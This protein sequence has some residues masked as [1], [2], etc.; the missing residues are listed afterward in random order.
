[1]LLVCVDCVCWLCVYVFVSVVFVC[2]FVCLFVCALVVCAVCL[3]CVA[4]RVFV[5][6]AC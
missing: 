4:C 6:F 3:N 1:M 2:L 5:A